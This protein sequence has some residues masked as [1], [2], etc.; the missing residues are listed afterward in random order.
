MRTGNISDYNNGVGYGIK[1]GELYSIVINGIGGGAAGG[2]TGSSGG[3]GDTSPVGATGAGESDDLPSSWATVQVNAAIGAGLA[4]SKL[5]S[6]YSQAATRA[7]FC[8]LAVALYETVT[9]KTIT[10]RKSFDDT[11]DVNVEKAA[12]INVVAGIGGGLFDPDAK[13]TR[14]Q[15]AVMLSRLA[16]AVGK[17]LK[18]ETATFGDNATISLWAIEAAGQVQ[19][20]GI[21]GGV[22]ENTFAPGDPYTREQSIVTI[23]RLYDVIK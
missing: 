11:N 6:K 12:A 14:E 16:D 3:G 10:E 13:L 19:A 23:M 1:N 15:A 18:K 4:P 7:E 9:E 17:P 20:A 2:D 22:G 21:M 8:A 5:Q